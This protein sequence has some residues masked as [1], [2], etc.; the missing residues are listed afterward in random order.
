MQYQTEHYVF[1]YKEHSAAERDVLEIASLQEGCFAFISGCLG[2]G[3]N[4]K[5]HYHLFDTPEE[6]GAQY[7][8]VYNS[9]NDG[10]CNGFALPDSRSEDGM[11]HVFAVYN[12]DVQCIGFHEDAHII[13]YSLARPEPQFIREGLAMYFDRYWWGIDNYS[14][15][16]YYIERGEMPSIA[17]LLTRENFNSYD[18]MI[19]YPIAGAFTSYLID[20][21]G[22]S[23]YLEFYKSC[24]SSPERAF[25][26]VFGEPIEAIEQ[27]FI[28][29]IKMFGLRDELRDLMKR[30]LEEE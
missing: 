14:R 1:H 23:R 3:I 16:G 21:C 19:T 24:K 15:T 26:E 29:Y 13:S 28:G 9:E 8:L 5:I 7:A 6:V 25:E 22:M 17:S 10:P 4:G 12:D 20:R 18:C 11:N 30:D 2:A 27:S